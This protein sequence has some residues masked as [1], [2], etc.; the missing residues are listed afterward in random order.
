MNE[1]EYY[2]DTIPDSINPNWIEKIEVLKSEEQKYIYGDGNG[3]VIIYPHKKYFEQISLLLKEYPNYQKQ[4]DKQTLDSIYIKALN[5]RYDLL[6]SSGQKFIEPNEQTERIKNHFGQN[7]VYKFLSSDEL[8]NYTYKHGKTL[9]LYRLT[10][11]QISKD[12]IDINFGD[13]A[14][15]VKKGIFLKNGLHFREAN[16]TLACGGTNGYIPDFRFI[17]DNKTKTWKLIGGSCKYPE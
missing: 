14:L 1:T 3:I 5:S 10:H 6:L 9:R 4:I 7:S 15:K 17:Y 12:T 16:Y 13:L 8:F 11:K 2:L